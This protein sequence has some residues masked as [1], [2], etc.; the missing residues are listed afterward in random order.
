MVIIMDPNQMIGW[1]LTET[2]LLFC[3]TFHRAL[4]FTN[5]QY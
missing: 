1:E 4:V 2:S 5:D 3:L